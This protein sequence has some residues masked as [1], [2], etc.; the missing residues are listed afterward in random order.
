[1]RVK[2]GA[3]VAGEGTEAKAQ[4]AGAG[5][6]EPED[7]DPGGGMQGLR[8]WSWRSGRAWG[9]DCAR[10]SGTWV[11]E[12][13]GSL[14]RGP[15]GLGAGGSV[16][17]PDRARGARVS[18]DGGSVQEEGRWGVLGWVLLGAQGSRVQAAR[19]RVGQGCRSGKSG[20]RFWCQGEQGVC[21]MGAWGAWSQC[22][23]RQLGSGVKGARRWGRG[24]RGRVRLGMSGG[25]ELGEGS[26]IQDP[27]G[28]QGLGAERGGCGRW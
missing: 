11:L 13:C 26:G 2:G 25:L 22:G 1:M 16:G 15:W 21:M 9:L 7:T 12:Y 27:G 20:G 17:D 6:G 5:A 8:V 10:G 14:G 19:T 18:R 4:G 3:G 28:P 24:D 23:G